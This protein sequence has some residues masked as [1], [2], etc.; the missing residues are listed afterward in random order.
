MSRQR[1]RQETRDKRQET[2]T[3]TRDKRQRVGVEAGT[4]VERP[5]PSPPEG[6]APAA[7]AVRVRRDCR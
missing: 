3:E 5:L 7:S 4:V 6:Q 2:E 1:Q